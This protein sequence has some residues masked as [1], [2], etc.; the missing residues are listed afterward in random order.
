MVLGLKSGAAEW[1]AGDVGPRGGALLR[2]MAQLSDLVHR[3]HHRRRRRAKARD[4]RYDRRYPRGEGGQRNA[5][6]PADLIFDASSV[7][8]L[9]FAAAL[10]GAVIRWGGGVHVVRFAQYRAGVSRFVRRTGR[11]PRSRRARSR[12]RPRAPAILPLLIRAER[13]EG[14]D[15]DRLPRGRVSGKQCDGHQ[16]NANRCQRERIVGGRSV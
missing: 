3:I 12:A 2:E 16:H 4:A 15:A 14:I 1:R 6:A 13:Y 7:R 11:A 10:V 9:R 5:R 8:P